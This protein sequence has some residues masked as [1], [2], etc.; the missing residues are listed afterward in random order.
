M[1]SRDIDVIVYGLKLD[2][3]GRL[4][5]GSAELFRVSDEI[6]SIENID[7]S[8]GRL[9]YFHLKQ[10]DPNALVEIGDGIYTS[11]S[12]KVWN[13]QSNTIGHR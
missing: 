2:W 4:F 8:N 7:P 12:R 11:V 10:G 3:K 9:A 13:E 5:P 1:D 6:E